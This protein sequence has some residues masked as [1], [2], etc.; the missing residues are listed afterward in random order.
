MGK[1][2]GHVEGVHPAEEADAVL[3][4]KKLGQLLKLVF[5]GAVAGDGKEDVFWQVVKDGNGFRKA[6]VVHKA[7]GAGKKKSALGKAEFGSQF[8]DPRGIDLIRIVGRAGEI[9][10]DNAFLPFRY[11]L[12]YKGV[13]DKLRDADEF[14][15][16]FG[17][18]AFQK[19]IELFLET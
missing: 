7:G 4:L 3:D 14:F 15:R 9:G 5:F 8:L 17:G 19:E 12:L 11:A 2:G 16:A 6:L 18:E 1:E 10:D 13:L